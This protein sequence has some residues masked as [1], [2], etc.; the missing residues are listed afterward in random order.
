MGFV[1]VIVAAIANF[2]FGAVWYLALAKPWMAASGVALG[3]DGQPAN[4]S[5]PIP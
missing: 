2:A 3:E 1:S 5:D 4:R